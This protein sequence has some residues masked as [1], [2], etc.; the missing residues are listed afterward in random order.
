V[1]GAFFQGCQ[2]RE[3]AIYGN[4]MG[5]L[6]SLLRN[7][8]TQRLPDKLFHFKGFAKVLAVK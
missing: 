6:T 3:L 1:L 7:R 4:C 5:H 8:W 2:V